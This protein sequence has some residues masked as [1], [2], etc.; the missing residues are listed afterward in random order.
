[1]RPE[2]TDRWIEN[3]GTVKVTQALRLLGEKS[4]GATGA[5]A[6]E[7]RKQRL[8]LHNHAFRTNEAFILAGP[9]LVRPS[10]AFTNT[11]RYSA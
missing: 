5:Q 8:A 3:L 7:A 9:Q 4:G 6:R 1:M 11:A 10:K 2:T